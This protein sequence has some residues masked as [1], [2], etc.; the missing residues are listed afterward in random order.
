MT[1]LS[2]AL[3]GD[4][5]QGYTLDGRS[6]VADTANREAAMLFVLDLAHYHPDGIATIVVLPEA[7]TTMDDLTERDKCELLEVEWY[8]LCKGELDLSDDDELRTLMLRLWDQVEYFTRTVSTDTE[9]IDV[10]GPSAIARRVAQAVLDLH[11]GI[12]A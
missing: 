10:R 6:V 5:V 3:N 9:D 1:Y 4:E 8:E 12:S 7:P 11:Y 2:V